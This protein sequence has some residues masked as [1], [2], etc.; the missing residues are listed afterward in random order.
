MFTF[1]RVGFIAYKKKIFEKLYVIEKH[2][3]F[4]PDRVL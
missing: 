4:I 3:V 2:R 1:C